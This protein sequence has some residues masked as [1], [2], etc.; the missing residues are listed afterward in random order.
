MKEQ[1]DAVSICRD[2]IEP[3][4]DQISHPQDSIR[5]AVVGVEFAIAH[6]SDWTDGILAG[7]KSIHSSSF[8]F[9]TIS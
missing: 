9:C 5:I 2:R 1:S 4:L 8:S 3:D 7:S 6:V